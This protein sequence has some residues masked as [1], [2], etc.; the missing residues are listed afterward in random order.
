MRKIRE[1]LRLHYTAGLSILGD[2]TKREGI[3][4]DGEGIH[5]VRAGARA[6]R[7]AAAIPGRWV[8]RAAAASGGALDA[9]RDPVPDSAVEHD[10]P[11]A[12]AQGG[13]PPGAAAET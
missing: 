6:D 5:P 13:Q 11:R 1:V 7:A 4:L 10:S 3:A 9:R 8:T 2:C 12:S